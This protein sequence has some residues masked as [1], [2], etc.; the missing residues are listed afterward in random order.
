MKI[1]KL[2]LTL[3]CAVTVSLCSCSQNKN[4]K[5]SED[6]V[7]SIVCYFSATGHTE[8]AAKKVAYE[9]GA[10]QYRII[11][12][13]EYTKEDLDWTDSTSRSSIERN[14]RSERPA[15]KDSTI[16]LSGYT[17]VY[18]GYPIWWDTY[19]VIIDSFIEANDLKGKTIVPF[20]TSG[21]SG[22]A[23]SE[24]DLRKQYPTLKFEKGAVL[25]GKKMT[26]IREW[27]SQFQTPAHTVTEKAQ[28]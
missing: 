13:K 26:E 12:E 27:V 4:A 20:A 15:L 22:I 21:G 1:F 18:L 24:A 19:P 17:I 5:G 16:D 9:A 10:D 7:K 6:D 8:E 14:N 25:N 11:P 3:F 23:D 2:I 28:K